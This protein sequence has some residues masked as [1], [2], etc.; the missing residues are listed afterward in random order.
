MLSKLFKPRWQHKDASIRKAAIEKMHDQEALARIATN[1]HDA[2]VREAAINQ[3]KD[4]GS[5][6]QLRKQDALT[7]AADQRI[8]QLILSQVKA[9]HYSPELGEFIIEHATPEL[10]TKLVDEADDEQIRQTATECCQNP[11]TLL[12]LCT[13]A[14]SSET[15]SAAAKKLHHE[16]AIR[17]ALKILGKR[18]KRVTRQLRE[19]LNRV[20]EQKNKSAEI[21]DIILSLGKLG[22]NK[23]W[24]H[25]QARL[26]KLQLR[27]DDSLKQIASKDQQQRWENASSQLTKRLADWKARTEA[28]QPIIENK[29]S[30]CELVAGFIGELNKRSYL[31]KPEATELTATLESFSADWDALPQLP[32][33][34]ETPLAKRFNKELSRCYELIDTLSKNAQTSAQFERLIDRGNHLLEQKSIS[35]HTVNKLIADWEKLTPPE[36]KTLADSLQN[37]FTHLHSRLKTV[38]EKQANTREKG[39]N[40]IQQWLQNIE[41]E[42]SEDKISQASK[43]FIKVEQTLRSL[44]E[45]PQATQHEIKNRLAE[46]RPH[47]RELEGWRHWGTD[48]AREE[49]IDEATQLITAEITI[50]KRADTVKDLRNRWKKLGKIDPKSGRALWKKFDQACTQ[51]YEPVKSHTA[52]ERD[53][54]NKNLETRKTICEQLEKIT[55]DTDWKTPDWR[56]IDKRF[57]KLRS[58]WRNAGAVNRKDWNAIN[59]RFNAAVTEL[60]EHLDNERRISYNRRVALIEKVEAIKDNEDLALAIQTAKD[61]QK[62]WQPTVTGKRGDEQKLWKQ[63]RAAIDHIFD[64][65]KERRESDSEET[66]ALL[67]EKQAICGSLEKLAELKNDDLLNAQ[68][69][70]HKLE[71]KWDDLGDIKIRPYNKIQS[72]YQRAMKSFED[73]YAK[74]LHTQKKTQIIKQLE[75]ECTAEDISPDTEQLNLLLL[76]MEIILE[77]DSPE[78]QA[79]ARMQLQVERLADAMSSSGAQNYFEE[80]LGLSKQLC[81]QRKA[82]ADLPDLTKRIDAIRNA[83]QSS[84]KL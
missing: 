41:S 57:N 32:P 45:A 26:K 58:Q 16:A 25:D 27:W 80:L 47:L 5:L 23:H 63:F 35:T 18:D 52:A 3:L 4:L 40:N 59:E 31:R 61:A 34:N 56:D 66:N 55:A 79:D 17:E 70:V 72:R 9:L 2:T 69:E 10:L 50:K 44:P 48:R 36:N 38:L 67:R 73:A 76:E 83:I 51:A 6:L 68:S 8:S 74:Q 19:N 13:T 78:D 21:E 24:Q 43:L 82:G 1:D 64:R 65:D 75:G 37:D 60:D 53:A 84:E 20:L 54:R 29:Q 49:L 15:R 22:Q 11:E 71:Q 39:L 33:E 12:K 62:S 46:F 30:L 77:I 14:Q 42:L 7:K 28:I 81:Q